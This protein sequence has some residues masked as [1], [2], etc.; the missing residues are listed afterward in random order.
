VQQYNNSMHFL[1]LANLFQKIE[2]TDSSNEI[3]KILAEFFRKAD[4]TEISKIAYLTLGTIASSYDDVNLGMA[5]KMVIKSIA[6][7]SK[8]S[9]QEIKNDYNKVGDLGSVAEKE[10]LNKRP[11]LTIDEVFSILHKIAESK[12]SGSSAKKTQLLSALL[13]KATSIEAKYI[14]RIAL[15]TL[16]MGVGEMTILNSLAI[17][18][19]DKKNKSTI[20]HAYNICPDIGI[21]AQAAAKNKIKGI[22]PI[23]GRPIKVMLCQREETINDIKKRMYDMIVEE[24]YD[25]ERVQIHKN[26]TTTFFSRRMETITHQY[27]E[28]AA[29]IKKIPGTFIIEGEIVAVD[30]K[31]GAL[32]DF[33]TLMQRR[34]KYDIEK[35]AKDIPAAVFLFD[36]LYLNEKSCIDEPLTKRQEMLKKLIGKNSTLKFARSIRTDKIKQT[37]EFFTECLQRGTEGIIVKS[38]VSKYEPGTRGYNWIKWKPEYSKNLRDTFDLVI[39]GGFAG[40]GR[41]AQTYG[42]LLCA[43]YN[44]KTDTFQT[45]CKLG[46]GFTDKQLDELP[47][48]M[49]KYKTA[50]KPSRLTVH[51]NM[52]PDVWFEPKIV[53]EV[54]GAEITKS[55]LH[56]AAE[57]G[58][59]LALRFPRFLRYRI[60]KRAEQSTTTEE[61][62]KLSKRMLC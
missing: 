19:S 34:R 7:A 50:Q 59:G 21:I 52:K 3:Q 54:T 26:K 23:I 55:P 9:E 30:E 40:R 62:I 46:S 51:K 1:N 12:G 39:V 57:D 49:Q 14:T 47:K 27:P 37:E 43:C 38:A 45:F 60:D 10:M 61:I 41:R 44:K 58:T 11:S 42:A 18:F 6:H 16:R 25:G 13:S 33:Q 28:I 2:H 29:A 20:E 48:H 53:V 31:T 22:K 5:D 32:K 15:G 8:K 17:A 4:D 56:T 24:K 36:L 35:Y